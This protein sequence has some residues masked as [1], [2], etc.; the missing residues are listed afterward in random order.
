MLELDAKYKILNAPPRFAFKAANDAA[1]VWRT[2]CS[3]LYKI[4]SAAADPNRVLGNNNLGI[5][6][7]I[8]K[9]IMIRSM[10][11]IWVMA[12]TR[13]RI[14]VTIRIRISNRIKIML[15]IRIMIRARLKIG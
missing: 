14:N 1:D 2:K 6:M 15:G 5:R 7:G 4:I 10:M 9:R 8:M 12:S 13:V 3:H 11:G